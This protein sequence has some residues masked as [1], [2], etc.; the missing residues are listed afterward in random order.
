MKILITG[1]NGFIGKNLISEL[2]N[3]GYTD[4]LCYDLNTD[5]TLLYQY[6]SEC[7][8]VFHLAGINRPETE[9]EYM[10]GNYHFTF[11]LLE[12][13]KSNHNFSPILVTSSIQASYDNPY[14]KSKKAGE[15]LFMTYTRETGIP[16]YIYRLPG[17]FGKWSRPNYN[18]VI[19]TFSHNIANDLPIQVNDP[20]YVISLVYIDDVVNEFF[21]ALTGKANRQGDYCLVDPVYSETL[22]NIAAYIQAFHKARD[23]RGLPDLSDTFKKKL[24]A[25]YLSYLPAQCLSKSLTMNRDNRGSFTEFIRTLDQGQISVNISGAGITKGN[26]WH[27]TKCEKFLVVSGMGVIRLRKIGS[28]EITSYFVSGDRLEAVDIPPGYTHNITNTGT[29]DMVTIMWASEQFDQ[30]KPDTYFLEV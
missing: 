27:H 24:Y 7:E 26:H 3:R 13:L 10:E 4:L 14:G 25:T 18:S 20:S 15:K 11:L 17:V 22:E 23:G 5:N 8:F 16:T 2:K 30:G 6:C 21:S 12:L 19:A 28:S 1:A 9:E 29:T